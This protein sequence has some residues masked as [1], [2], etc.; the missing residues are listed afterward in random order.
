MANN[1]KNL[2][3][4]KVV[5][6]KPVK[7]KTRKDVWEEFKTFVKIDINNR[8]ESLSENTQYFAVFKQAQ[9]YYGPDKVELNHSITEK[10]LEK[11]KVY[12]EEI[13]KRIKETD[14]KKVLKTP[15]LVYG[16]I[17]AYKKDKDKDNIFID[18]IAEGYI[19]KINDR[20]FRV[21]NDLLQ[22][23]DD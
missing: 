14:E 22:I 20:Y 8:I 18:Y 23:N 17:P 5:A 12:L 1:K 7:K 2:A 4:K 3:S 16:V 19:A 15:N 6:N 9:G 11:L 13:D 21:I 10:T